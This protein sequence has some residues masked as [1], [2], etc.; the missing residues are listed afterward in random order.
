MRII[1]QAQETDTCMEQPI[2]CSSSMTFLVD[3]SKLQDREDIR[4][5]DLGVWINRVVKSSFC[6]INIQGDAVKM[7]LC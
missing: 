7:L 2:G 4:A 6:T 1:L 5:D 3:A